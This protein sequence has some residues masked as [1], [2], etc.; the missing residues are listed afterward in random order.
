MF[1]FIYYLYC[2]CVCKCE[3]KRDTFSSCCREVWLPQSSLPAQA[4]QEG[5]LPPALLIQLPC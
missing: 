3:Q 2:V 5:K 4:A 1:Y